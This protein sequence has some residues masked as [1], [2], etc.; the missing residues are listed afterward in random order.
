MIKCP[1]CGSIA[2]AKLLWVDHFTTTHST[3][4]WE[5]GCGC[6]RGSVGSRYC[7]FDNSIAYLIGQRGARAEIFL[8]IAS[9]WTCDGCALLDDHIDCQCRLRIR[10]GCNA[11]LLDDTDLRG[12]EILSRGC[13]YESY[14]GC[15]SEY[16][17][18]GFHRFRLL[19]YECYFCKVTFICRKNV[20]RSQKFALMQIK[21]F[22]QPSVLFASLSVVSR[23]SEQLNLRL[24]IRQA[25][26]AQR[27]LG[28]SARLCRHI[29]TTSQM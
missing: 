18:N 7:G 10:E 27:A 4:V 14:A 6:R 19:C 11:I 2:Q 22:G 24:A 16:C 9:V 1:N 25:P 15:R 12:G 20:L 28:L 5:C 17:F 23:Q 13:C 29:A 26:L 21:F 3:E 8:G